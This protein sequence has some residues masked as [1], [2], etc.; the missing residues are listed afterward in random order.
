M[1]KILINKI[2]IATFLSLV[3]FACNNSDKKI[4]QNNDDLI[5]IEENDS[6]TID[7]PLIISHDTLLTNLANYIG[8]T[9]IALEYENKHSNNKDFL[10]LKSETDIN[11][12]T[13]YN[14]R[15][16][17]MTKWDI[18]NYI[19]NS[20][21]SNTLF[22]PFSGPDFLHVNFLYPDAETYILTAI[23]KIGF[24]PDL[25][26]KSSDFNLKF[27]QDM[28]YF[29]R[30]IY[31]RS[32]FITKR[33]EV[34]L[35]ET[36]MNGL[37]GSLYWFISR[38][39]HK[40]ISQEFITI[41]KNGIIIPETDKSQ[42]WLLDEYDG[43]SF[44]LLNEE[45]EIKK[46]IY[47]SADIS[48]KG[49]NKKNPQLKLFLNNLNNVNTFVKSASYLMHYNSFDNI[50]N[51]VLNNSYSLFQDDTGVPIR[52]FNSDNWVTSLFGNYIDPIKDF[53]STMDIITQE[54]LR[55]F[56]LDQTLNKGYLPFS[57]GYHW[58]DS[59]KQNQ[60]LVIKKD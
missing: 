39:N 55:S 51:I 18:S 11:F 28:N 2:L 23:E 21:S 52:F 38:T 12:S 33:M 4:D 1:N 60:Q 10:K 47:F 43:V 45:N 24:L 44:N 57:L 17:E 19:G 42:G 14:N 15:L 35:S 46:L 34:D 9:Q 13:I 26:N 29:M 37:I 40:I 30:D 59:K 8:L 3:F 6:V 22:Y 58:R 56:Y 41:D 50:R 36:T 53:E 7:E 27:L 32:Y 49:L 54:D 5:N 31:M 48:N 25:S 16:L 20:N